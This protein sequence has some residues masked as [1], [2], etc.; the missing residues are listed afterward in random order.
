MGTAEDD[1]IRSTSSRTVASDRRPPAPPAL[2]RRRRSD[3]R[4]WLGMPKL[5]S[6]NSSRSVC[7][8]RSVSSYSRCPPASTFRINPLSVRS[9]RRVVSRFVANDLDTG[10]ITTVEPRAPRREP[11]SPH[12]ENER[13]P[14]LGNEH[15]QPA[16]ESDPGDRNAGRDERFRRSGP[17]GR[18]G[19]WR[20]HRDPGLLLW[21]ER[22]A[23]VHQVAR[24]HGELS[25]L[26]VI[27]PGPDLRGPLTSTGRWRRCPK[28]RLVGCLRSLPSERDGPTGLQGRARLGWSTGPLHRSDRVRSRGPARRSGCSTADH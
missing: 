17:V 2:P 28:L 22:A 4:S 26:C 8:P 7:W 25:G 16:L 3:L 23:V 13:K 1:R 24:V 15:A 10:L 27:V 12:T 18:H 11:R 5:A 14:H 20:R 9:A 21:G 19:P 6:S